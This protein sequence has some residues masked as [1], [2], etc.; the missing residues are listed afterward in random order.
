[1]TT[2]NEADEYSVYYILLPNDYF[3]DFFSNFVQFYEALF[4]LRVRRHKSI[5]YVRMRE[6]E[7]TGPLC[8]DADGHTLAHRVGEI[9]ED[10]RH[11]QES[12]ASL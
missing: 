10:R 4:K 7:E 1:M 3:P 2:R 6:L 5:L 12:A 11:L 9:V 8:A